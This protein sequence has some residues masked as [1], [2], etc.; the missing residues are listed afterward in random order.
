MKILIAPDSFK[1]SMSALKICEITAKALKDAFPDIRTECIPVADGGEG[2]AESFVIA[3]SAIKKGISVTGPDGRKAEAYIALIGD[4]AVVESALACGLPLAGSKNDPAFSTTYGVGEMIK[5]A[6][7]SGAKKIAIGIGGSAT[8][9]GG[10]GCAAAL[11]VNFYDSEGNKVEP[12]G[13]GMAKIATIDTSNIDSRIRDTKITVLCDVENPLYGQNGAA[14]VYAPQKGAD[15]DKVI[16]L[17]LALQNLEKAVKESLNKDMAFLPGSGAAGGMG[18]GLMV[19]LGAELHSGARTVLDLCGFDEKADCADIII[20]GEGKFDSQSLMGKVPGEI[21]AR[22]NGKPVIILC[23]TNGS[24]S[25]VQGVTAIF[26][27]N[28]EHKP[29]EEILPDCENALYRT[30]HGN[31]SDFL[32]NFKKN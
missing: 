29:F 30:V 18:Y 7:D 12:N 28:P 21:I 16:F 27:T 32:K 22:A 11:G 31:V 10:I 24:D 15:A 20:T 2:T 5:A 9:D 13:Y 3:S 19:F 14:Y 26:E 4:T 23:G 25:P 8:N 1:G 6:L 17:D